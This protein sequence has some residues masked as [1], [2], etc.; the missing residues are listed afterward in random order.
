MSG[1]CVEDIKLFLSGGQDRASNDAC[2][3]KR[4]KILANIF[5]VSEEYFNHPEFG[6]LWTSIREKFIEVLTPLCNG[7]PFKKIEIEQ[8]GGMSYNYDFLVTILG[9]LNEETNKR[10]LVKEIKLEFKHNN[11]NILDLAQF[12]ELYDKDCKTKFEIC[13]VSYTEFFYDRYL[14]RYI[15]LEGNITHP[16]PSRDDYLKNVYDIKYKHPFF[17]NMYDT[18]TNKTK[19][20]RELATE[21]ISAYLQEFSSSFKFDKILEKIKKSQG[22]KLFLFWDCENFH[23]QELIEVENIN[24]LGI[25][26]IKDMYFDL[27]LDNYKNDLRVR[28]NWGNNACVANPRWKFTFIDRT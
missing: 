2:N 17:K 27:S 26:K 16:K 21:S 7:E 9:Q 5:N 11:S 22:G 24:I 13:D 8:K 28:I 6:A 3:K 19:E 14:D 23:I 10:S 18:K 20:K 15:Q 4:E 25:K 1:F 12:L